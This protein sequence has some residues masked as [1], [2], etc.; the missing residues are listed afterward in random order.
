MR[1]W[2]GKTGA[3]PE[4][5]ALIPT[6]IE[7]DQFQPMAGARESLGLHPNK[8]IVL[9]CGRLSPEKGVDYLIKAV[10]SLLPQRAD[11]ELHI[12]GEGPDKARLLKLVE[13]L[14]MKDVV[15]FH[16]WVSKE[17]MPYYYSAADVCV[18]P[19]FSEGLP[20]VML[21]AMA[22]GS[23]FLGTDITGVV[24]HIKDGENG[25]RVRPGDAD[26]LAA[27]LRIILENPDMARLVA[28]NAREYACRYLDWG[29]IAKRVREEVFLPLIDQRVSLVAPR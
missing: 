11:V 3:P 16:G 7:T 24:D 27:K 8:T 15:V 29:V 17:Q 12:L 25:F 19:S 20:R 4:K 13:E 21:E 9:Y 14:D 18:L 28:K 6:G 5:I 2:W 26:A 1:Y 22:C 23:V 10:K